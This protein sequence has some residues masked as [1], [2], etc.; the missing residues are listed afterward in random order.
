[1]KTPSSS[2][3][4]LAGDL[5]SSGGLMGLS[6]LFK[7]TQAPSSPLTDVPQP[8]IV[9]DRPSP[10][11]PIQPQRI[12]NNVSSPLVHS[13]VLFA[14]ESSELNLNYISLKESQSRRD[15]SLGERLTRSADNM[16][17][18][19]DQVFYKE[20]S[21][22]ERARRQREL[23]NEAGAQFAALKA[24]ARPKSD[25]TTSPMNPIL[26]ALDDDPMPDVAG[27]EEETE[28]E[29]DNGPQVPQS[30]EAPQ[31]SEEDKENYNGPPAPVDAANIAHDR[32]SQ[33]LTME[34]SLS[35]VNTMV[36]PEIVHSQQGAIL[37]DHDQYSGRSSQVM[38]KDSQQSPQ[39]SAT[40][41]HNDQHTVDRPAPYEIQVDPT[42]DVDGLTPTRRSLHSSPPASR[43]GS[44]P[45]SR[46]HSLSPVKSTHLTHPPVMQPSQNASFA[47]NRGVNSSNPS[48]QGISRPF[49]TRAVSGNGEKSSSLPSRVTETPVHLRPQNN[50]IG[51][52][53]SIPETS[54]RRTEPNEWEGQSNGGEG[55]NEDDDLPPMYATG[56]PNRASQLRPSQTRALSSPIKNIQSQALP[57]VLSSPS[58]RQRRKL[59]D[60]ASDLSPQVQMKFGDFGNFFTADDEAYHELVSEGSP[61]RPKKKRRGNAGQNFL[62]SDSTL[63][64]LPS[65]PR[66]QPPKTVARIPE[67]PT[68][69]EPQSRTAIHVPATMNHKAPRPSRSSEN[70]WDIGAS[71]QQVFRRRSKAKTIRLSFSPEKDEPQPL[72]AKAAIEAPARS[73]TAQHNQLVPSSE[74]TDVEI[75]PE[76][77]HSDATTLQSSPTKPPSG[78]PEESQIAPSQ[79]LAVWMGQKR[80]YYP[81]TCL[82]TPLGVSSNKYS[83]K[84]EDSLPVE[85]VR[86]P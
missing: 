42:S 79:V 48:Q 19:I 60:I 14:R 71:P 25:A 84:F 40:P 36:E 54:P 49:L 58:G 66:A 72:V 4:P 17:D 29:E 83:V 44:R 35:R 2:R 7:A 76:M 62:I 70:V 86:A 37:E 75:E 6:Q 32:L 64:N 22:V 31:S 51:R 1:M 59:T 11:L 47:E 67:W 61:T 16:D 53:T 18:E 78:V 63:T 45:L 5:E 50:D 8:D 26:E 3:N 69:R 9:S 77:A 56:P 41:K 23:D 82:G 81:A 68:P 21:F 15:K 33:A 43:P 52:L 30:Q 34:G 13:R 38:V 74:L 80:A 65:T 55:F 20:S 73:V 12:V 46:H 27:S 57:Q 39:P 28:Q 85:V 10:N 24:F